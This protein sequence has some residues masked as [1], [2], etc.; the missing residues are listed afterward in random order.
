MRTGIP[1]TAGGTTDGHLRS[2]NQAIQARR[3]SVITAG[4]FRIIRTSFKSSAR[5]LTSRSALQYRRLSISISTS[6]R[7]RTVR[8]L[9]SPE[10]T[11]RL[12][13]TFKRGTSVLLRLSGAYVS[14]RRTKSSPR[15]ST[16]R[17]TSQVSIRSALRTTYRPS[18]SPQRPLMPV[19]RL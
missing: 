9:Q 7:E 18:R 2:V 12:P 11:T 5:I 4:S 17:S 16:S 8:R 1:S 3:S 10:R 13:V 19:Q 6:I 15:S 14:T